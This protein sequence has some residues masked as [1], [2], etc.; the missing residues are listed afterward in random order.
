[1]ADKAEV[2]YRKQRS[3]VVRVGV[4]ES[5]KE[6]AASFANPPSIGLRKHGAV[7]LAACRGLGLSDAKRVGIGRFRQVGFAGLVAGPPTQRIVDG[8]LAHPMSFACVDSG[9]R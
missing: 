2:L 4:A 8:T 9:G 1:D 5:D 7:D 3:V 6:F